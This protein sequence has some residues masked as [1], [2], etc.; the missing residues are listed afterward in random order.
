MEIYSHP[1]IAE[2]ILENGNSNC[3]DCGSSKPK[4]SSVNNGI[5]LCLKCASIHRNL[6]SNTSVVK[7][8]ESEEWN[9]K[10]VLFLKK[11]G[12]NNLKNFFNEYNIQ[13]SFPIEVKFKTKASEYYRNN[14]RNIV[15]KE[16]NPEFKGEELIKPNEKIGN[17]FINEK[18]NKDENYNKDLMAKENNEEVEDEN[19]DIFDMVGNFFFKTKKKLMETSK[20]VGKKLEEAKI[21][22]KLK[23]TGSNAVDLLQKGGNLIVQKTQEA[24]NSEIVQG[25]KKKTGEG[26]NI[27]TDKAKNILNI[28]DESKN[29]NSNNNNNKNNNVGTELKDV[30]DKNENVSNEK[31]DNEVKND[32]NVEEE[33]LG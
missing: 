6:G 25:I 8:L 13:E 28:N 22:D 32:I 30:D 11:G 27:I 23:N 9:D 15:E 16:L 19:Q 10:Q 1:D 24:Y 2:I 12:N 33:N 18:K 21:M 7:S 26:I 3:F 31:K 14:L 4:W 5:F 20:N 17:E 29:N